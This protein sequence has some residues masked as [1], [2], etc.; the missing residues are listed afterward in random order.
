M[1]NVRVAARGAAADPDADPVLFPL[2]RDGAF[3]EFAGQFQADHPGSTSE[4]LEAALADGDDL[5]ARFVA[6]SGGDDGAAAEGRKRT[7]LALIKEAIRSRYLPRHNVL[8]RALA[9]D[10]VLAAA[11]QLLLSESGYRKALA[12][13]TKVRA[14]P[15]KVPVQGYDASAACLPLQT[16]DEAS[17]AYVRVL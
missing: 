17:Y 7:T 8:Y 10:E 16:C 12:P 13:P 14:P 11:R 5:L 6:F 3:F 9:D 1:P 4:A 15:A 2:L